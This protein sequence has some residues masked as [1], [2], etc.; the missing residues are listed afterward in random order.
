L[1][2]RGLCACWSFEFELLLPFS[3]MPGHWG[4]STLSGSIS[5]RKKKEEEAAVP[6]FP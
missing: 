4:T 5:F 2:G 1:S 6:I 3:D